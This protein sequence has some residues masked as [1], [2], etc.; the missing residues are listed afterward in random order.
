M[1]SLPMRVFSSD[2]RQELCSFTEHMVIRIGLGYGHAMSAKGYLGQVS[3]NQVHDYGHLHASFKSRFN[4][5]SDEVNDYLSRM[6]T[7]LES[8]D[9]NR[10][11]LFN[12]WSKL[13]KI[14]S[15]LPIL[16]RFVSP[17]RSSHE[18]TVCARCS[19]FA[20]S[21]ARDTNQLCD[22]LS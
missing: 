12:L 7:E 13:W 22:P 2:A 17:V 11:F 1:L 9:P 4:G 15:L 8:Q 14:L 6:I 18:S 16:S 20:S 10:S 21:I 5:L 19:F 3:L